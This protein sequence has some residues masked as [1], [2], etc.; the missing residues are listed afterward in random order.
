M[1]SPAQAHRDASR[2]DVH[3]GSAPAGLVS[4][5]E[6]ASHHPDWDDFLARTAGGE[7]YDA[8]VRKLSELAMTGRVGAP[9]DVAHAVA[10][11]AS[12]ESSFITAQILTVD[13]GRMD[14]IT[15][16]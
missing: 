12:P 10:F 8:I 13:G 1:N 14:Y 5:V 9:E 11:L 2:A 7:E 15:H 6:D 3:R 4:S 16:P